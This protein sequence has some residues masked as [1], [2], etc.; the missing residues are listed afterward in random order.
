MQILKGK[1]EE[2]ENN[3]E[4]VQPLDNEIDLSLKKK[5]LTEP[6]FKFP[7]N[8]YYTE[9]EDIPECGF[10]FFI[11]KMVQSKSYFAEDNAVF[12]QTAMKQFNND[13][14]T[15]TGDDSCKINN[16]I[17]INIKVGDPLAGAG[18]VVGQLMEKK[19]TAEIATSLPSF[20]DDLK[21]L[22]EHTRY[23][24][25]DGGCICVKANPLT[26]GSTN[27]ILCQASSSPNL[28]AGITGVLNILDLA[29]SVKATEVDVPMLPSFPEGTLG[30]HMIYWTVEFAHTLTEE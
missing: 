4:G 23:S 14:I 19:P 11:D 30:P 8:I 25:S 3:D 2:L 22:E 5:P 9:I 7:R 20:D 6:F 27:L 21:K 10:Q 15:N 18:A 13:Q 1:I 16:L 17:Q 12:I 28:D 29:E 26:N 24:V